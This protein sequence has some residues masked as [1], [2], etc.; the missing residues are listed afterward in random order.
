MRLTLPAILLAMLVCGNAAAQLQFPI[1]A[2]PKPNVGDRW[3]FV[4]LDGISK[5][6]S[7]WLE[8]VVV[9]VGDDRFDTTVATERGKQTDGHYDL[10]WNAVVDIKGVLERQQKAVFP[11][12][13]GKSWDAKWRWINGSGAEGRME[14]KYKVAGVEKI[15]VRAG[16]FDAVLVEGQG[17]WFNTTRGSTGI[18]LERRWYAPEAGHFI[19]RTW[20]TRFTNGDADQNFIVEASEIDRKR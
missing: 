18:A 3:K 15:K 9:R 7:G 12:E 14:M 19:R 17:S 11:F 13:A 20:V 8:Q 10:D 6:E 5:L 2:P 4:T 16:E 1:Q